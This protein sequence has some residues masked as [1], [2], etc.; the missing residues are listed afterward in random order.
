MA[1]E[2]PTYEEL[3]LQIKALKESVS[4]LKK[5]LKFI[6]KAEFEKDKYTINDIANLSNNAINC[7]NDLGNEVD[8]YNKLVEEYNELN[9]QYLIYKKAYDETP[10]HII[11]Y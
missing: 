4:T 5:E 2:K 3:E 6:Q 1:Q 10:E 7:D 11:V 9:L 8:K